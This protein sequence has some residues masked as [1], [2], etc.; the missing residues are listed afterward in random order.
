MTLK[1]GQKSQI[2]IT[3]KLN[4]KATYKSLNIAIATVSKKGA[5]IGKKKG[6]TTVVVSANGKK[7]KVK[8]TVKADPSVVVFDKGLKLSKKSITVKKGK[9]ITIKREPGVVGKVTFKALD[10]KVIRVTANG[11]VKAKKR[12]RTSVVIKLGKK[13]VKLKVTVKW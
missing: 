6:K 11:V 2:K 3:S 1:E 7:K 10:E 9:K 8:V 12:G 5:V 13:T 4:T